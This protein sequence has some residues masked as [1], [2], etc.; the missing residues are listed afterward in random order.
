MV[1]IA[2]R[3]GPGEFCLARGVEQAP[4]RPD[5]AFIGLPRLIEGFDDVVIDA[6]GVGARDEIA[7]YHGLLDPSR[8]GIV[9]VIAGAWP[10]ELGNH[11]ALARIDPAQLIIGRDREVD[12]LSDGAA[13]PV[14][15]DV[16]GDEVDR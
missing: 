15:Q 5:A 11:N 9:H 12:R 1:R 7:D 10:A 4:I 3:P 8:L 2:D 16:G 14:G 6:V 13:V